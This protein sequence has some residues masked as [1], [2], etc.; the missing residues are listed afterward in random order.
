MES[1]RGEEEEKA[2]AVE[3]EVVVWGA[4][5]GQSCQTPALNRDVIYCWT[6]SH[7]SLLESTQITI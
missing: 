4:E 5:A 7:V 6:L 2:A 3:E 1:M